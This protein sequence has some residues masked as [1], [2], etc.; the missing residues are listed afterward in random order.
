MMVKYGT[1]TK[2]IIPVLTRLIT[3]SSLSLESLKLLPIHDLIDYIIISF[4]EI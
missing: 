2:Y 4:I 3:M 1:I